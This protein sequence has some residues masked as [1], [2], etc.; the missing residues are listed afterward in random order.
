MPADS[1]DLDAA[2]ERYEQ[3]ITEHVPARSGEIPSFDLILL[4]MGGDGHTA[5]LFPLT[6]PWAR[7]SDWLFRT[8]FPFWD[9]TE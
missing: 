8:S 7:Q 9:G 2:A 6:T 5:S 1:E 4:G 3:L